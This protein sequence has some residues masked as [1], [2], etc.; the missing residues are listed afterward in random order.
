MSITE[1]QQSK[2]ELLMYLCAGYHESNVNTPGS[3][4]PIRKGFHAVIEAAKSLAQPPAID[5]D[6]FV[7]S[8]KAG[9]SIEELFERVIAIAEALP[10]DAIFNAL[11]S[12]GMLDG[13]PP[14]RQ[15]AHH[16]KFIE[17]MEAIKRLHDMYGQEAAEDLPEARQLW[18]QVFEHA[19]SEFIA[20][21]REECEMLNLIPKTEFV[22]DAGEPV[23]TC[24]QLADQL[25]IPV[26]QVDKQM[27]ENFGDQ[28]QFCTVHRVQ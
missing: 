8:V 4:K 21:V 2:A 10:E 25:G 24:Q 20:A 3:Q 1:H 7:K 9:D 16:Q 14:P 5:L 12:S 18:R 28:L 27:R 22:N 26:E 11:R 19:P 13:L 23:Y 6:D 15:P 17:A